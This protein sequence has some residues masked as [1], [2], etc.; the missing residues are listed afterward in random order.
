MWTNRRLTPANL[1]YIRD[2][3]QGPIEVAEGVAICHGSPLDEV[4]YV[5]SDLDAWE[6]FTSFSSPITFFGHTHIP[7]LTDLDRGT[8]VNCGDWVSNRTCVTIDAGR[9]ALHEWQPG[10]LRGE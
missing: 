10:L 5:F 7:E 6:I 2:L 8:F 9:I 3:P 4:S 1:R